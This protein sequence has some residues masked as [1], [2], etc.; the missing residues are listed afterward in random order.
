M[1]HIRRLEAAGREP[2]VTPSLFGNRQMTS[3]LVMFFFQFVVMMG[4]FFVVPLYLSVALGPLG[5][6]HRHQDHPALPV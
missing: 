4:V 5:D 3:G 1:D 2:L 6:R